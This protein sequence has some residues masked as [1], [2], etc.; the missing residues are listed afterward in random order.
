MQGDGKQL[1]SGERF[2]W[3]KEQRAEVVAEL[4]KSDSLVEAL[5]VTVEYLVAVALVVVIATTKTRAAVIIYVYYVRCDDHKVR[6][7]G[8]PRSSVYASF[9]FGGQN[10]ISKI[11]SILQ[12]SGH[13]RKLSRIK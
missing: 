12:G 2:F 11:E 10:I 4:S 3:V 6:A 8:K 5:A 13:T 7:A 9:L 1:G